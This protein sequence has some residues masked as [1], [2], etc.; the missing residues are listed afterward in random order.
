MSGLSRLAELR[1]NAQVNDDEEGDDDQQKSPPAADSSEADLDAQMG[2]YDAIRN[3]LDVIK[4]HA[5]QVDKLRAKNKQT[6][7]ERARKNVMTQMDEIMASTNQYGHAIKKALDEIKLENARYERKN[8]EDSA[9]AQAHHNLYQQHLKKFQSAMNDYNVAAAAFKNDL[10]NRTKREIKIVDSELTEQEV[11]EIVEN[12]RAQD[13]IRQAL[14]SDNLQD[15]VRAIEERHQDILRLESQVLEIYELFRD[16]ATLVDLQQESLDVIENRIQHARDYTERAEVD[17]M[18]AE[19]YQ[20]KARSRRCCLLLIVVG[21]VVVILG[22]T[23][24]TT[25]T[26]G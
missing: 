13:V 3:G 15:V 10:Q 21:I 6:A 7:N 14:V 8:G 9:T 12:G 24:G 17:L 11:D 22:P 25:L 2:R 5:A 1:R 18:E 4:M 26:R 23:L 20:R 19:D 16:L